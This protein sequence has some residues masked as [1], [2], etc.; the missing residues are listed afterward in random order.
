MVSASA[1]VLSGRY[2]RTLANLQ[3]DAARVPGA[4]LDAVEGDLHYQL[5]PDPD[6]AARR[7]CPCRRRRIGELQQPLGLPGEQRRRSGP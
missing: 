3:R 4:G 5:R 2:R 7:G 1:A 6:D